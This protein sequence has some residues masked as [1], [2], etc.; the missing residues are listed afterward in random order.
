L[1]LNKKERIEEIRKRKWKYTWY[2]DPSTIPLASKYAKIHRF[3]TVALT[4]QL[5]PVISMFFLLTTAAGSALWV[6]RLE[7]ERRLVQTISAE[8]GDEQPPEYTDA[9]V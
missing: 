4:L 7:E 2:A 9:P 8:E 3:G 6:V 5:V 1:G